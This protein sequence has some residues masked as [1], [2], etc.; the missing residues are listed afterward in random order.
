MS[1]MQLCSIP[2][3]WNTPVVLNLQWVF[4]RPPS[5]QADKNLSTDTWR[6]KSLNLQNQLT[7]SYGVL[8]NMASA[9]NGSTIMTL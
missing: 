4:F 3:Q 5:Q 1:P 9:T 2:G 7:V 8:T 6:V